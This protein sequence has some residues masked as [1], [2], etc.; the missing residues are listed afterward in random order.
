MVS[1]VQLGEMCPPLQ[2]PP[3]G[4]SNL[5]RKPD[6][7]EPTSWA[8]FSL[9]QSLSCGRCVLGRP[10]IGAAHVS[11]SAETYGTGAV[12]FISGSCVEAGCVSHTQGCF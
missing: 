6:V 5:P 12:V 9:A 2:G 8:T 10:R 7:M 11:S 3:G 4:A 1:G